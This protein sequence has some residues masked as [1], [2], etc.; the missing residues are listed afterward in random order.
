MILEVKT[1]DVIR[2]S[3]RAS[4]TKQVIVYICDQCKKT[5]EGKYQKK[6]L[7]NRKFHFCSIECLGNSRAHG[8]VAIE[9]QLS[10]RDMKAWAGSVKKSLLQKYGVNNASK[11][12][13]VKQKKTETTRKNYGVDNPQ[14]HPEIKKRSLET[15]ASRGK[16][17]MSAPEKEF[18]KI[19]EKEFGKDDVKV[20]QLIDHKWSVDFFIKSIQ[21]YIQFDGVYWHGLDRPIEQIKE[22]NSYRDKIIY[23]K[24]VKDREL[25]TVMQIR[26]IR[27]IRITDKMFKESIE[28]CLNAVKGLS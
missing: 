19:L 28:N 12:E 27:L 13:W 4:K 8:G 15:F 11:L 16:M 1:I 23:E 21:T 9:Y 5:Y 24:W 10:R 18:R 26:G 7:S 6:F 20:Q 3:P 25:D 17:W 2:T 22:S 14:Q